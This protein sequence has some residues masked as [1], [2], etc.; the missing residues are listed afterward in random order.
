MRSFVRLLRVKHPTLTPLEADLT[1]IE[2]QTACVVTPYTQHEDEAPLTAGERLIV[3]WSQQDMRARAVVLEVNFQ[4]FEGDSS[5]AVERFGAQGTLQ[6][7]LQL[8]LSDPDARHYPRLLGGISVRFCALDDRV[9]TLD[10]DA[11]LAHKEVALPLITP[12]DELMDFSV[13]GLAFESPEHLEGSAFVLCEVGVAREADRWRTSAKVARS[14]P[15][16]EGR[17]GLALQFISPPPALTDA[18][19]AYTLELQ[20]ASV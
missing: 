18:L 6:L 3:E 8:T 7:T 9:A 5:E 1:L 20:R 17:F 19:S 15:L 12:L 11:W 13:H 14:W 16:G 4:A 10:T 2:P